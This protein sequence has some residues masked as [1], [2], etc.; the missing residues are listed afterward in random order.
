MRS[1]GGRPR[2]TP[3]ATAI[4]ILLAIGVALLGAL[5]S[6]A[7]RGGEALPAWHELGE[8]WGT[9]LSER[10]WG[11]PREAVNGDPWGLGYLDAIGT[12]YRHGE[13]GIF[14]ISD[15][16]GTFQLAWVVWDG[17]QARVHE[18]FFG[19]GNPS[20]EHG[21][22]IL[23]RRAFAENTLTSSYHR[24]SLDYPHHAPAF[25]LSFEGARRDATSGVMCAEAVN[26]VGREA[27]LHLALKAWLH[28]SSG[29]V[30][31]DG[32]AGL[33]LQAGV[34]RLA[35]V[36]DPGM[37]R[38][39]T[40]EKRGIDRAVREA[41]R[42]EGHEAGHIGAIGLQRRLGPDATLRACFGWAEAATDD[43]A[44]G[45][46]RAALASASET[47]AFRAGEADRLF[48]DEVTEHEALYRQAL[49]SLLWNQA[50]YRWDGASSYAPEWEGRVDV[51]DVL[52][53]PD[54]WEFPWLASWDSAFHAVTAALIDPQLGAAQL[55]FLLGDRWLQDDGHLPCAEFVMDLECPPVFAWAAWRVFEA[56]A[57]D[58]FLADVYPGLASNHA[59]WWREQSVGDGLFTGGFLG[60]DN[61]P[62]RGLGDAERPVQADASAWMAFSAHHLARI[63]DQLGHAD[64]ARRY[65]DEIDTI[66]RA[67]NERL[68]SDDAEV[69]LDRDAS[70]KPIRTPSY[71]GLV[72]LIAGIVPDERVER[73]L[74]Q[75]RHE[76]AFL[77]PHGIRSVSAGSLLYEPGYADQ[78][79]VNSN[80][81]GPI[82]LPMN[83]L[84]VQAL[85]EHDPA[86]AAE[87]RRRVVETVERDWEATGRLHEY[88][89]AE[90][91][92]GLGA[93]HQA[94]WTALVANL[95]VEGWPAD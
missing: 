43:D 38:M 67:V 71:S 59:Y 5:A 53:M 64:D 83:Y 85:A 13:D 31:A 24:S 74:A 78:R 1:R 48:R 14:G 95:I 21:E 90:T 28:D 60:M 69:Y 47:V 3:V 12:P 18:R 45:A 87:V 76:R 4:L 7:L 35:V 79:G 8:E 39:S 26:V 80:W 92:A 36:G 68:W 49:M 30:R 73:M 52:I 63:A 62:G 22:E 33:L 93:D 41:G 55:R 61:L 2:A 77:S 75:L 40:A 84:L 32:D 46:A 56:G 16:T 86:L 58:A 89:D 9:Y 15:R 10:E 66:A 94:G 72:P 25:V 50:L 88:F 17:E 23:D 70:G 51:R 65:R 20:G 27:R 54:R 44:V 91:G 42:L 82:W 29:R 57:G 6:S 34:R 81:R 11:T 19:W 37:D